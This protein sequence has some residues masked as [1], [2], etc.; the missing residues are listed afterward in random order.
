MPPPDKRA[1]YPGFLGLL[2]PALVLSAVL[3]IGLAACENED[4]PPTENDGAAA[5][6]DNLFLVPQNG[7]W[8]YIDSSGTLVVE[9]QFRRAY[10]FYNGLALVETDS[11]FGYIRP[12]GEFAIDPRFEDAWH[13]TGNV[14]PVQ[15]G[16]EWSVIDTTGKA[17]ADPPFDPRRVSYVDADY[18]PRNYPLMHSGGLYGYRDRGGDVVVDPRYEKAWYFTGGLA[19]VRVDSLWGYIDSTGTMI[20][21]PA[22]DLAWD[23]KGGVALVMVDGRYGYINRSGDFIWEPSE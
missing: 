8:G 17:V 7:R 3:V 9:P 20:I 11:G 10:P 4:S 2:A 21:D 18:E 19:R 5:T 16:G 6:A 22:F 13:F 14:A 12:N 1:D 23:F 15:I